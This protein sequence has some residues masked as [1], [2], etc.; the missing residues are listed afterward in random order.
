MEHS[1]EAVLVLW[2]EKGEFLTVPVA[3]PTT[4][5][6]AEVNKHENGYLGEVQADS[7]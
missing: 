5:A 3:E 4:E 2:D 1:S 7:G 6:T